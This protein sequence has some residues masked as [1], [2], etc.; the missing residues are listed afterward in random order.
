MADDTIDDRFVAFARQNRKLLRDYTDLEVPDCAR[1][2]SKKTYT[3]IWDLTRVKQAG[4]LT[5]SAHIRAII[6]YSCCERETRGLSTIRRKAC[7][8]YWNFS[9]A[10][11]QPSDPMQWYSFWLKFWNHSLLLL[12][13]F[14]ALGNLSLG[15]VTDL[16]SFEGFV[17]RGGSGFLFHVPSFM[18]T[19]ELMRLGGGLMRK[20]TGHVLLY[21]SMMT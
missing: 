3:T 13:L 18:N 11:R 1:D 21:V 2:F 8:T 19:K 6:S 20:N 14:F 9:T 10:T 17:D 16:G 12:G 15:A 7:R 5:V 4:S